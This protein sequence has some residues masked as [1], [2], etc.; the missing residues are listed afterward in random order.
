MI[1]DPEFE[2][3]A[4]NLERIYEDV[5]ERAPRTTYIDP[6]GM[7]RWNTDYFTLR[8][9]EGKSHADAVR[10]VEER[11]REIA[12]KPNEGPTPNPNEPPVGGA[13]Q[14]EVRGLAFY[15]DDVPVLPLFCHFGEAFSAF[16]RRPTEVVEQLRR[17]KEAGYD[18]I[19]F[20][21]I[22]GFYDENRP[23][24][25]PWVAWKGREV[26]PFNFIAFSGRLIHRTEAYYDKLYNF[27]TI[28]KNLGLS[29]QHSR[30]DLCGL[31]EAEVLSHCQRVGDI[32]RMVGP[33][34]VALNEA[35]NEYWQN[36]PGILTTKEEKID[37]MGRMLA[38]LGSHALRALSCGDDNYGGETPEELMLLKRDVAVIHGY[39]GENKIGHIHAVG[40]DTLPEAGVPGWQGEPTGPGEGVS[41]DREDHPETLTM[42]ALM[43]FC[44]RQ[45]WVY[46]S[47]YGV[48]W[49]GPI[50]SQPGFYEVAKVRSYIPSNVM[51]WWKVIHGGESW[52]NLRVLGVPGVEGVR[53]DQV[54]DGDR[55]IALLHGPAGSYK[56]PVFRPFEGEIINP[57][58]G[59]RHPF[60]AGQGEQKVVGFERGRLVIGRVL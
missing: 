58:T 33:D 43:A 14:L 26:T 27:L 56:F 3:F 41:V 39:R 59:E 44:T 9:V 51:E 2:D 50:E 10:E 25:A 45:A 49:D 5:L 1:T 34:V 15:K 8:V 4:A 21:D 38:A 46:M 60:S 32:Q 13:G 17:I 7:A 23:G 55:F 22:L 28:C 16:T 6:L 40:Y 47:G 18:G 53:A 54:L 11:I 57:A 52:R 29:V 48:F 35:C 37:F 36:L 12:G 24:D 42:M 31:T 30:G 19:R 20:W